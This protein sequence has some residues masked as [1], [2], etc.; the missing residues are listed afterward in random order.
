MQLLKHFSAAVCLQ[1]AGAGSLIT[2]HSSLITHHSSH[3]ADVLE[4]FNEMI[5]SKRS[6]VLE[7]FKPVSHDDLEAEAKG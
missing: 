3:S 2:H 4:A 1:A 5:D 7:D 6:L